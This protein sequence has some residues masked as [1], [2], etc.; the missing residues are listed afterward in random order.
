MSL[1]IL[2]PGL[3]SSVQD[4]GRHGHAAL[5]VGH[6][7]AI[8]LPA[9]AIANALVGNA[10]GAPALEMTVVGAVCRFERATRIAVCGAEVVAQLDGR[11]IAGWTAIDVAAGQTLDC[12]RF[13]R[14]ARAC[15][16]VRGGFAVERVL[17]S[18]SA[19]LNGGLGPRALAAGDLLGFGD[20]ADDG[21]GDGSGEVESG[22]ASAP[23]WEVQSG[24]ASE[25]RYRP[26]SVDPRLWFDPDPERPLRLVRGRHYDALDATSRRALFDAPFR[27]ARDSNRV[28]L[29]LEGPALR[30]EHPLEL[31]SEAVAD[32]SLQLPPGGQPIMLMAERPT[33]GGYPR[34]GQLA[35]VDL[36][37]LGQR[38][39]GDSVRFV[40]CSLDDA[41][42]AAHRRRRE[43]D[44]L[45]TAIR[46]RLH[47]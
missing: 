28:G 18:A 39:P 6:A 41:I 22:R 16:A 43:L 7:G 3:L 31:V 10:P 9:L 37:R 19:D 34:I 2:K 12:A 32:G 17:G 24:R 27:I 30:L 13:T 42:A 21:N 36:A 47:R 29:R 38:R 4:D 1:R 25:R 20:A 46:E 15:L 23:S 45:L 5:G 11:P 40:E 26:F 8:D 14:G 44:R 33:T 35:A